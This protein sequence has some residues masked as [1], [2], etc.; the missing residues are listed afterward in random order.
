M[1]HMTLR[2]FLEI[3]GYKSNW[4]Y[5]QHMVNNGQEGIQNND[6]RE[7]TFKEECKNKTNNVV[8]N[9]STVVVQNRKKIKTK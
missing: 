5:V 2:V 4:K 8:M 1:F 3:N 6:E 9:E 7:E